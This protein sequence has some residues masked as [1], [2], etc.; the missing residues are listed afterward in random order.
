MAFHTTFHDGIGLLFEDSDKPEHGKEKF[1]FLSLSPLRNA[2]KKRN[3]SLVSQYLESNAKVDRVTAGDLICRSIDQEEEEQGTMVKSTIYSPPTDDEILGIE[4]DEGLSG[5]S[6]R[7]SKS[8]SRSQDGRT[9]EACKSCGAAVNIPWP[10]SRKRARRFCWLLR[11]AT[12]T[13]WSV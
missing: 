4:A 10:T 6:R 12:P 7:E 8:Q 13:R 2:V 9:G 1:D 3:V 11:V 5:K